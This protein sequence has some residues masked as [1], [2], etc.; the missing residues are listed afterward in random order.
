MTRRRKTR[1]IRKASNSSDTS[2]TNSKATRRNKTSRRQQKKSDTSL[3][4]GIGSV[5]V[6]VLFI[7][8]LMVSSSSPTKR[9]PNRTG[10]EPDIAKA[11]QLSNRGYELYKQKNY[12]EAQRVLKQ[13]KSIL[14]KGVEYYKNDARK[15]KKMERMLEIVNKRYVDAYHHSAI[16]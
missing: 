1:A 9:T 16:K 14:H 11:E 4:I 13:A 6:V 3:Y 2:R 10:T 5:V 15:Q 12:R 7:I 8:V